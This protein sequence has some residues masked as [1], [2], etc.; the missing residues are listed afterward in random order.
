MKRWKD[1]V[2][3]IISD[4][5][6]SLPLDY[7]C[8]LRLLAAYSYVTLNYYWAIQT[9][10]LYTPWQ[11]GSSL[12]IWMLFLT[13]P[14]NNFCLY[15]MQQNTIHGVLTLIVFLAFKGTHSTFLI[16][17]FALSGNG[18]ENMNC[19]YFHNGKIYPTSCKNKY[20][21]MCER[22]AGM[23]KVDELL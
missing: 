3:P 12:M 7:D 14:P 18:R 4:P 5:Y 16:H 11:T 1:R 22:K 21:L 9:H 6:P 2:S 20:Y 15:L 19:A 13:F 8:N 17:R 10:I 23:V